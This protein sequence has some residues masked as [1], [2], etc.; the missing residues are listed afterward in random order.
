MKRGISYLLIFAAGLGL[1]SAFLSSRNPH[2]AAV[3]PSSTPTQ[4]VVSAPGRVEP[5]SEEIQVGAPI[6]GKLA[7]VL[8]EEGDR[9]RAGQVVAALDNAD[10]RARVAVAEAQLQQAEAV[11]RRVVNGAR[12]QERREAWAAVQEA[13]A[14]LENARAEMTRRRALHQAGDLSRAEAERAEREYRVAQ[15]RYEAAQQRHAFVDAGAR[16]EDRA[17]AEA[18]VALARA[19][20]GEARAILEKTIIRSPI[21]GQVLRRHFRAGETVSDKGDIPIVTVGDASVL[22]VR[23][24]VDE[25]D[26]ARIR[27]GQPAYVTAEA[28][29]GRRFT[30]RVVRVGRLLGKKNVR[31]ERPA[32]RIDT[33]VLETL[34]ELDPG[35]A[36]PAGLRVDAFIG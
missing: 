2:A 20:V 33:K 3:S 7:Q 32:E 10:F 18:D 6:A 9:V 29:G 17:K 21:A 23:V 34:I 28:Y 31:T 24:E 5:V 13:E 27:A 26:V 12:D 25:S 36:L 16:E 19:R 4:T 8:V 35:Q 11:L 30:G 14:V 22:R 15:S 1:A